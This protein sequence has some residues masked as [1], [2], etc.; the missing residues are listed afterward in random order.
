MIYSHPEALWA[1]RQ[2]LPATL[3][4]PTSGKKKEHKLRTRSTTTRDRSVEI[5][6]RVSTGSF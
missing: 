2:K 4:N 5:S 6:G 3:D 1:N